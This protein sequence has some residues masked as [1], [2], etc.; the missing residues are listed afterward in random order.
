MT[1]KNK[2]NEMSQ[3]MRP[4][5]DQ[6][7][8]NPGA[9][10]VRYG[11]RRPN[12]LSLGA[13]EGDQP[14]PDF[15]NDALAEALKAGHT[16]YGPILGRPELRDAI[17]RYYERIYNLD[18]GFDRIIVT[19]S[20]SSA[21][22]IALT[23]IIEKGDEVVALTPLWKNLLGAVKLQQAVVREIPLSQEEAGGWRLDLDRLFAGV[24]DRT[25]AIMVNSPN[26]PT[27][28]L[29]S[30][31]E[32]REIMDFARER[33]IW[34]IS[35]EVYSRL[36]YDA[37]RAPSFLDVAG[38]EDRLFVINSFS[39]NWAMTGW[40]LGWLTVPEGAVDHLYDLILYDNMGAPNFLQF[41]GIAALEQGEEFVREFKAQCR[42]NRDYLTGRLQQI[43]RISPNVP[44]S[45]FYSFFQ[46]AGEPDCMAMARRLI[47]DQALSLAPGCSFGAETKG[48]L[49]LCFAVSRP[50]LEDALNRL[51]AAAT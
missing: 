29:I 47:D 25:R 22:H 30:R 39:K 33:G 43:Y 13:G 24:N 45:T 32:M 19:T 2:S 12:I 11:R 42:S 15:I 7:K 50:R 4:V 49:R 27:G 1:E 38:P 26:N 48:F 10:I 31:Q 9:E 44:D 8:H 35:D 16:F 18:I 37:Q 21:V 41:G 40:R 34:V 14:T 46:V 23:S 28:W 36:V 6:I 17:V 51:E 20:G 5:L 3:Y